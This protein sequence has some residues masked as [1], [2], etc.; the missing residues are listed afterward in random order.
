MLLLFLAFVFAIIEFSWAAAQN[1]E[2]RHAAGEGARAAAVG[3]DVNAAVCDGLS[4]VRP[5]DVTISYVTG[6]NYA[7]GGGTR[8]L[9][10]SADFRS[11]TGLLDGVNLSSEHALYAEPGTGSS[12]SGGC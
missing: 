1:N 9:T 5:G 11:L 12:P 4:L 2:V 10:V 6:A 8:T 7:N 3:Q